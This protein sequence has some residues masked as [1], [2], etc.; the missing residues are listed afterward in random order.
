MSYKSVMTSEAK[1]QNGRFFTTGNPFRHPAFR[2]WAQCSGL[3]SAPILEPFAGANSL[4]AHLEGMGLC[5]D[6]ASY[7]VHPSDRR[8]RRRDTLES[9]P[10]GFDVCVTNPPWLARNSATVRG[11]AFPGCRHDDLYKFALEKC[12]D[13]CGWVAALVPESFI[14]ARI[15][16]ERLTDFISLASRLFTDTGHPVGLALFQPHLAT[17]VK[18]W[19]QQARVGLLSELERLRPR[20]KPDGPLVRFNDP[21][22]N[23]GLIAL[24]NTRAASIRFCRVEEL[25]EYPVKKTGRHITKLRVD[26]RVR[27]DAWNDYLDDFRARTH[28]VLMT[29]YKGIRKDGMYRRRLDWAL[30]RGIVHHA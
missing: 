16:Q 8:V 7:D 25:A 4:I 13:N 11:L 5:K 6:S 23:V 17:D 27:I 29:C 15:F 2:A 30:A 26:G 3:P 9:F 22:G 18:V 1:R 28:D 21:R 24:D 12:L 14:R 10:K 19:F 20:P